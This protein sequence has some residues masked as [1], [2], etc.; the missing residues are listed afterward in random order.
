MKLF[1]LALFFTVA[2]SVST[3]CNA[4]QGTNVLNT[5]NCEDMD[6]C[7]I[8]CSRFVRGCTAKP[9]LG[10]NL[11]TEYSERVFNFVRI[12]PIHYF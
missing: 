3:N 9:L 1:L 6:K 2:F 11:D 12:F 10:L 4:S 7:T 8:D 5:E